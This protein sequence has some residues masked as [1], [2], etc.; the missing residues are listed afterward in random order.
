MKR[1][2]KHLLSISA[3]VALAFTAAPADAQ[4]GKKGKGFKKHGNNAQVVQVSKV[5]KGAHG[6]KG[7]GSKGVGKKGRMAH[8]KM[9]HV[10]GQGR[11]FYRKAPP[12][13]RRVLMNRRHVRP[14]YTWIPGQWRFSY[15]VGNYVWVDG[16]WARTR[17]NHR[18]VAGHWDATPHGWTFHSGYWM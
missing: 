18:W 5:P 7:F 8:A 12:P 3:M 1:F 16:Y 11:Y 13:R 9:G 17:P 15:R 6:K 4:P 10:D 14:G 2:I